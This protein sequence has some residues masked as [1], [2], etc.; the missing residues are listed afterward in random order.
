MA[1]LNLDKGTKCDIIYRRR[2]SFAFNIEAKD[3][4]G[5]NI[6]FTGYTAK[7]QI[8]DLLSGASLISL[9]EISGIT[10]TTGNIAIDAGVVNLGKQALGYELQ[11]TSAGGEVSTF[12]YGSIIEAEDLIV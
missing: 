5:T 12:L 1:I 4:G 9:T 3:S 2:D 11:L 6:N 10:L 8:K 7:F